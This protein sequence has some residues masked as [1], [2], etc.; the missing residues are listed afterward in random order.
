MKPPTTPVRG[1]LTSTS[2]IQALI[3]PLFGDYTGGSPIISYQIDYDKSTNAAEW[4]E[5]KG[6][7]SNDISLSAIKT[8]LII[9]QPYQVRYRA[10]NIFGW[11]EYSERIT[12][13]TI[14]VPN[15]PAPV[16]TGVVGAN[17]K[18]MWTQPSS[19]GSA[20][21]SYNLIILSHDGLTL[22]D[23]GVYCSNVTGLHCEIPMSVL[24][25]PLPNGK[26]LLELNDFIQAKVRAVNSLGQGN[27]SNLNTDKSYPGVA[28]V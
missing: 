2:S 12:I 1:L 19:N 10:K 8:G 9:S 6:F 7:S 11:G 27:F 17:V 23:D 14:M 24:T 28:Y 15:Q 4:Q 26:L 20:I 18:F 3:N 25:M 21:T 22:I 16:T 13:L 5:L